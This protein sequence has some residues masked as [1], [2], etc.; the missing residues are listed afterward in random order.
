MRKYY[1]HTL[2]YLHETIALGSARSER[3]TDMFSAVYYPMMEELGARLFALWE[4]TAYNGHWPQ[5]TIIWENDWFS[6]YQHTVLTGVPHPVQPVQVHVAQ[7][8]RRNR[9]KTIGDVRL[10]HPPFALPGL[11]YEHLQRIVCRSLRAEPKTARQ[12][13]GLEDRLEH[14]LH[15]GRHDTVT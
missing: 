12:K 13:P 3:F 6:D 1:E 8:R 9:R 4:T 14:D 5:V 11:V 10:D 7:Q 2:L 15:R